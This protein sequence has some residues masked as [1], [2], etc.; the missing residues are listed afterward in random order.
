[1]TT[2]PTTPTSSTGRTR[3]ALVAAAAATAVLGG[4]A[5]VEV[6][7]PSAEAAWSGT[8]RWTSE[9][10]GTTEA[11][12]VPAGVVEARILARGGAG[13]R[14]GGQGGGPGGP[15]ALAGTVQESYPVT[16]GQVI[17]MVVGCQGA[18]G[19]A[20]DNSTPTPGW[21]TGGGAGRGSTTAFEAGASGGAGGGSTGV[22]IGSST[23]APGS[24]TL[25]LVASGGGGGGVANC[26]GMDGA[27]S[28]GGR[29][30]VG[31]STA[32]GGGIGEDGEDG[33]S[34]NGAGGV[35]GSN[36]TGASGAGGTSANGSGG[37]GVNVVGGG[38]GG[39]Y[40]GGA[41]G[42][43]ASGPCT[44]GGGGGGGS[45][46]FHGSTLGY[47][48]GHCAA[49]VPEP[50]I[51]EIYLLHPGVVEVH[52]DAN[53]H[54]PGLVGFSFP[55]STNGHTSFP[56]DVEVFVDGASVGTPGSPPATSPRLTHRFDVP[57]TYRV[58]ARATSTGFSGVAVA[59]IDLVVEDPA[60]TT[61]TVASTT[62]T[63]PP[64]TTNPLPH[65]RRL[66]RIR[67]GRA[68]RVA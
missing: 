55:V 25:R 16:E 26:L 51:V 30:G 2:T 19:G 8:Q 53:P 66:R 34:A 7:S 22:C 49:C 44:G 59:A 58:E 57:G 43:G 4:L 33:S 15:G 46:W 50:G 45:D 6:V 14:G 18:D 3:R 48:G 40:V 42:S 39:G 61:P 37:L 5:L 41:A 47:T 9:R 32:G 11:I 63:T 52:P 56:V 54:A 28:A 24:A 60:A 65:R 13:G 64:T 35:G 1:M 12:T 68:P 21:T 36:A 38:G 27:N 10:C 31:A 62:P 17:S 29:G 23:C 20:F 67:A